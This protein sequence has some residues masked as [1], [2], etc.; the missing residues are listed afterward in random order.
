MS[1]FW[2]TLF[3]FQQVALHKSIAYHPQTNSQTEVVNR[4]LKG[5]LRCMSG[6]KPLDWVLRLPLVE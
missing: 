6:E 4:C 5:Y 1:N 3:G 2:S